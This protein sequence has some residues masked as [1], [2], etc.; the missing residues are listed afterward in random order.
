M[1]TLQFTNGDTIPV[2]GL[3]TWKAK[4]DEVKQAL[5]TAIKIGY[6][7]ID[8]AAIY[9]NEV[10]IGEALA[11]VFAEGNVTRKDLFITSKL[12][13]DAH[14]QENVI[15]ALKDSLQKLQLEYLDLY[16]IHW[17]VAFKA[18]IPMPESASDFVPLSEVPISKTWNKMEEAK[19]KDLVKHIGVSNFSVK[20]L[21]DLIEKA[22]VAPEVNQVELHPLLQQ[23]ELLQ[24][25]TKHNIL[26]T[27]Y[28]PLGSGDRSEQMKAA[29]EPNLFTI[30]EITSIAQKHNI[31]PAQ[32]LVSWHANRGTSVIPKSVTPKNMES[33]LK[34]GEIK[35]DETDMKL[36]ASLDKN[37]RFITG[38]FFEMPEKGYINIYDE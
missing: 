35:L 10:D 8:T 15:P 9:G 25:C 23:K 4:G 28:S 11:E 30:P 12:W 29:N 2:V 3:G 24:F 20:K 36:L 32:V 14:H 38:K 31:H 7:H 18:G 27:A 19:E 34:A 33:N 16:L 37:Y 5:K 17:P 13:N 26:L 6:R 21:S 1:K 22:K